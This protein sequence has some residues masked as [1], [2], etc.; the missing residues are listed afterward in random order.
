MV[1]DPSSAKPCC[2]ATN[3]L[4]CD[5][6]RVYGCPN[7]LPVRPDP[8]AS[9]FSVPDDPI[10]ESPQSTDQPPSLSGAAP[11]TSNTSGPADWPWAI[12][13]VELFVICAVIAFFG[14][15]FGKLRRDLAAK[16]FAH[17]TV[18]S[19]RGFELRQM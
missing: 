6:A 2:G 10:I 1:T 17:D 9:P 15:Y 18:A 3:V 12:L 19:A 7:Q 11:E 8:P 5:A 14:L 4:Q 13:A 16:L